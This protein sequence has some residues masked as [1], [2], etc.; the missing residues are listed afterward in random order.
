MAYPEFTKSWEDYIISIYQG[1]QGLGQIAAL[2]VVI[3]LG[4]IHWG[5]FIFHWGT[6]IVISILIGGILIIAP[7]VTLILLFLNPL[8][9]RNIPLLAVF[10]LERVTGHG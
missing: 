1:C 2:E 4:A 3:C 10:I 5:P 6:S 7:A 8:L 9:Y